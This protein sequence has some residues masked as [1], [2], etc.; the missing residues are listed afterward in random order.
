MCWHQG[1]SEQSGYFTTLSSAAKQNPVWIKTWQ[2]ILLGKK[3]TNS[4]EKAG[5]SMLYFINCR[6]YHL[7]FL[8]CL[9]PSGLKV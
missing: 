7:E 3:E 5:L 2:F 9:H 4:A 6:K 8:K 1:S